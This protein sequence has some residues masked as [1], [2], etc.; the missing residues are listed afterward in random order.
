MRRTFQG[1]RV[2]R[3]IDGDTVV[4][5]VDLGFNVWLCNQSFRLA[6]CN[7]IEHSSPGGAEAAANLATLLPAGSLI[8][9]TSLKPDKFGGRYDAIITLP[10][11]DDLTRLLVATGWAAAWDGRGP[12]PV[13]VWPRE[14]T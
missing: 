14:T 3:V 7:A 8:T 4:L 5:D 6:G 1:A 9:L 11:G 2:V 12:K 13:P 10:D